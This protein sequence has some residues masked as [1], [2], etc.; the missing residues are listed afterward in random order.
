MSKLESI[1][2]YFPLA[3]VFIKEDIFAQLDNESIWK[4]LKENAEIKVH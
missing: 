3:A 1:K 4:P 2:D